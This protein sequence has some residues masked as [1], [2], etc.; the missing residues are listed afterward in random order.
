MLNTVIH[1]IMSADDQNPNQ[2][3]ATLPTSSKEG[4]FLFIVCFIISV[5]H[6]DVAPSPRLCK[7]LP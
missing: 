1:K 3:R 2:R 5:N 6:C 7:F 4:K